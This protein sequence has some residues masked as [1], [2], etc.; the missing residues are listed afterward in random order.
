MS[1]TNIDA[2][3]FALLYRLQKEASSLEAKTAKEWDSRAWEMSKKIYDGFYNDYM[4]N[5][6]DLSGCD[7]LLDVGCGPGTF[8]I[9][10]AHKVKKAHAFDFSQTMLD[11]VNDTAQKRDINNIST[12]CLDI[13]SDWSDLP[14]C[15]VVI[16]SRCLEVKDIKAVLNKINSHAK[17][18]AYITYKV[19]KSFLS[20]E[21]LG[22]IGRSVVPKP[23]YIYIINVL[24]QMGI[25]A[26]V[27][28]IDPKND[29]YKIDTEDEFIASL[30]WSSSGLNQDE[31]SKA[32]E[33]YK[34]CK[35]I[36]KEP[37][38][39]NNAWAV[40]YWDRN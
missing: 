16:A 31:E 22:V 1:K 36:G 39:R 20:N 18:R 10:L 32:R 7:S 33:Y 8:A 28:F 25:Y 35:K 3:D 27:D 38:H 19:G 13:N 12:S 4:E 17:K 29:G 37:A 5:L 2:I 40:I 6:I 24:Y 14:I 23:D 30:T 34:E 15:D 9:K 11:V 21:I 26:K